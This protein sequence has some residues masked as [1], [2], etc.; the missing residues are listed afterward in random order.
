LMSYIHQGMQHLK[1]LCNEW[2]GEKIKNEIRFSFGKV[3]FQ[4]TLI[5]FTEICFVNGK[6]TERSFSMGKN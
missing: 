6:N 3:E 5:K 1:R 4:R 2:R